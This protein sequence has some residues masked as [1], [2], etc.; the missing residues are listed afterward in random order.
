MSTIVYPIL[1]FNQQLYYY[2][3]YGYVTIATDDESIESTGHCT[4]AS[5][6]TPA[7]H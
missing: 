2:N 6:L 7:H 3:N 5:L 1:E 4:L